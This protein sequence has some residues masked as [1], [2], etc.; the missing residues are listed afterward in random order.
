MQWRLRHLLPAD[1]A[2]ARLQTSRT[3][4]LI[5]HST[6]RV[7]ST[8]FSSALV[9]APSISKRL[10]ILAS[11]ATGAA[12]AAA[13]MWLASCSISASADDSALPRQPSDGQLTT[14]S[15]IPRLHVG[16]RD[17]FAAIIVGGGAGGCVT[18]YHL[19]NWMQERGL[20]G[21]VLLVERGAPH[22][23][24]AAPNP[25]L[26]SWFGE[27]ASFSETHQTRLAT[28]D[29][30]ATPASS[31]RGMGG[32]ST[33]DT[34]ITFAVRDQQLERMASAMQWQPEFLR[35]CYQAAL[36]LMPLRRALPQP[37][38]FF[39]A[40]VGT[41]TK[42]A[43]DGRPALLRA[44]PN[45]QFDTA[46]VEDTIAE[47]AVA[48]FE[49]TS[50]DSVTRWT[51]AHLLADSV[52]PANLVVVADADVE[53][54]VLAATPDRP[55]KATG[56][57]LRQRDGS[58]VEARV[59]ASGEVI[60]A[61]GALHS[62][63]ILQRS[64]IGPADTLTALGIDVVV[65]NDEVGHGC[66]HNEFG[67][68]YEWLHK[69]DDARGVATKGGVHGWPL[70]LYSTLTDEHRG[71]VPSGSSDSAEPIMQA[72]MGAGNAEPY[73]S[74]TA[75]VISPNCVRPDPRAGFRVHI[76]SPTD[77]H[78]P[79]HVLWA[80]AAE[81]RGDYENMARGVRRTVQLFERLREA[82]IVGR[83]IEPP[84]EVDLLDTDRLV[85]HIAKFHGSAFH[86]MCTCRA[87]AQ[88][89][90][91]DESF[92]VR[93]GTGASAGPIANLR[94]GSGASLPEIPE[95]NPHLTITAFALALALDVLRTRSSNAHSSAAGSAALPAS[96]QRAQ[97]TL[98]ASAG[99]LVTRAPG[100]ESPCLAEVASKHVAA[101]DAASHRRRL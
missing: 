13:T 63:A 2:I 55:I 80:S 11:I 45:N 53:R 78:A 40:V 99:T 88:D 6:R 61:A 10:S 62:P 87:G 41:L 89:G 81:M 57:L 96:L 65:A 30:F 100:Q 52:R 51:P 26:A 86:W 50:S 60:I 75:V 48:A 31:H 56:V 69:W 92:R 14:P 35:A 36:D 49:S 83:R 76:S 3:A 24:V 16:G 54:V 67:V 46:I 64:G 42:P 19:A 68:L 43:A 84:A 23:A 18:A 72:H 71:G 74:D 12:A 28:G 90:V 39:D 27:W 94:V 17:E 33:H 5:A 79:A 7:S 37:E 22:S 95:G 34:R 58:R 1:V 66:D 8:H 101:W 93:T 4:K 29:A 70:V 73:T 47:V 97:Q 98:R 77:L 82:G 9:P 38:P 21:T 32:A 91:V 44:M 85:E 20:P 15:A 59:D 25:D